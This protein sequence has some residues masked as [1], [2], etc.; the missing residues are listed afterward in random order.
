M[1]A[2]THRIDL[3]VLA[4][5]LCV[6]FELGEGHWKLGFTTGFGEK[7]LQVRVA[8]RSRKDIRFS[9]PGNLSGCRP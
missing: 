3:S 2:T 6:V 9:V 7:I 1:T 8:A 5:P 4:R